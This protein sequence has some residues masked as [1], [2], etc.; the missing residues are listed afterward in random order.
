[1]AGYDPKRPR[2]SSGGADEP[3]P[4][5]ALIDLAEHRNDGDRPGDREADP[6]DAGTVSRIDEPH[7]PGSQS[8]ERHDQSEH[9][10][11]RASSRLVLAGVVAVCV[12]AVVLLVNRRRSKR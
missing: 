5:D 7:T 4:V 9:R 6:G 1:M 3:A 10:S 2:P 11:G 12:I 8:P